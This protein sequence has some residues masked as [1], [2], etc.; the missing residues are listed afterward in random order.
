MSVDRSIIIFSLL[1]AAMI[2][3]CSFIIQNLQMFLL[4]KNIQGR[5]RLYEFDRKNCTDSAARYRG[6]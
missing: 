5:Y 1:K 4:D 6:Y 2:E 3:I